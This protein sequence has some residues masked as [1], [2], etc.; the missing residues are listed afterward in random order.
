[1][2]KILLAWEYGSGFGHV[3]ML[4]PLAL[5]LREAGHEPVLALRD[6]KTAASLWQ[7]TGLKIMQA[8]YI[9]LPQ[10][11]DTTIRTNTLADVFQ[12]GGLID[13]SKLTA[14]AKA[15]QH[16]LSIIQPDLIIGEFA[17]TLALTTLGVTPFVTIG[18]GFSM[19]PTGRRLPSIRFWDKTLSDDS[20]KHEDALYDA[21]N[22]TRKT[23]GLGPIAF[24]SDLFGGDQSFVCVLPEL[25]CY[26]EY[27]STPAIG[28]LTSTPLPSFV[29][30]ENAQGSKQAFI[31][32]AGDDANL[33]NIFTHIA[34]SGVQCDGYIRQFDRTYLPE[35]ATNIHLH[36]TPQ[37]L[38]QLLP[39]RGLLIHHGGMSTS[40]IALRLGIPQLVL[41]RH[42]EQKSNGGLLMREGVAALLMAHLDS[43]IN[44][45]ET[46]LTSMMANTVLK[47]RAQQKAKEIAARTTRPAVEIVV[48]ACEGLLK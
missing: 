25:D 32:L 31:Y 3:A 19:P 14:L 11:W 42:L 43:D 17:P 46:V 29:M 6:S 33:Q 37:P 26:G 1:M 20:I 34:H 8:P 22:T 39:K 38:G 30:Q 18:T 40:D 48:E 9:K 23:L 5:K 28:P 15:W 24:F 47:E 27:R 45:L 2:A 7:D 12:L 21:I 10:S 16:M 13:S 41:S 44:R 4:V 35:N 36:A